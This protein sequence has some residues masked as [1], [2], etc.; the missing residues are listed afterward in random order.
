MCDRFIRPHFLASQ[1]R[2]GG[3]YLLFV[4]A[5]TFAAT[6]GE[7]QPITAWLNDLRPGLVFSPRPHN[8]F[9][10]EAENGKHVLA[11]KTANN[12]FLRCCMVD[13]HRSRIEL[14]K[15][16]TKVIFVNIGLCSAT[17]LLVP[18]NWGRNWGHNLVGTIRIS[19]KRWQIAYA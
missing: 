6:E 1:L 2:S 8:H 4:T 5:C 16:N 17:S 18:L 3:I 15:G 19:T 11:L 9:W 13:V 10:F 7:Q 12:S 14:W